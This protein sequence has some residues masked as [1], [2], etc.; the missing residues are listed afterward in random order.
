MASPDAVEEPKKEE[1]E[2]LKAEE[3]NDLDT[4]S[5]LLL[6]WF[7]MMRVYFVRHQSTSTEKQYFLLQSNK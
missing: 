7:D 2:S 5:L 6:I 3:K 4:V 1:E